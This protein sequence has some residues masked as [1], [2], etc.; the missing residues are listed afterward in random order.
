MA[1]KGVIKKTLSWLTN[2]P[3]SDINWKG[4]LDEANLDTMLEALK[5]PT[6]SK[7]ARQKIEARI[8]KRS[9]EIKLK[10]KKN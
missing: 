6:I 2:C 1:R 5:N 10:E 8:R 3:V 4:A 7:T 9:R